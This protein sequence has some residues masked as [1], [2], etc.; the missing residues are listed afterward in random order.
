MTYPQPTAAPPP[1]QTGPLSDER[2]MAFIVYICYL[3]AHAFPVLSIVGLI[4]AYVSRDT[5][6][7]WLKSHY[8]FQIRTFWIGMLYWLVS[9]LLCIVLIGL[10]GFLATLIWGIVR[11]A[12]GLNRL[13]ARQAYPNP[14]SWIT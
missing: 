4:L 8:T 12:L 5:A 1:S 10:L 9:L 7:D 6:P 14:E 13:L 2:Q 11:C 3:A